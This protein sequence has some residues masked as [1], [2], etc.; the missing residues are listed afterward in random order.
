M[1]VLYDIGSV[2]TGFNRPNL[3]TGVFRVIEEVAH[4]LARQPDCD[5]QFIASHSLS[6]L[7]DYLRT[8][9]N[10]PQ[11]IPHSRLAI[12]LARGFE[13]LRRLRLDTRDNRALA[14]RLLRGVAA[15]VLRVCEPPVCR[16]PSS[17]LC[18]ADIFHSPAFTIPPEVRSTRRLRK[19]ITVYDLIPIRSPQWF[20]PRNINAMKQRLLECCRDDVWVLAISQ[21]TKDDFC[22]FTKLPPSRVFVTHLAASAHFFPVRDSEALAAARRNYGVPE[23]PFLLSVC[24]LEPRK[25]L[26]TVIKAFAELILSERIPD[27]S[28][29][30][31]GNVGWQLENMNAEFA[32]HP[33]LK[34][35]IIFTGYVPD[36]DLAAIYSAA[37]AFVYMSLYEGFGLPPLEAM[38]C[39]T[40]VIT[41]NVSSLP[42]VV[43]DAGIMVSPHDV[44]AISTAMLKLCRDSDL[45]RNLAAAGRERARQYTWD[46]CAADTLRAYREMLA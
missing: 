17:A 39:D 42:E 35:R 7:V 29:V 6:G 2:A 16:V 36:H 38:Q 41:S 40:P 14:M 46:K 26:H 11:A 33:S 21:A 12:L 4:A 43:G 27:L 23:G 19:V 18:E 45:R 15:A 13:P 5:L 3:R 9:P 10:L 44:S 20:P 22:E 28:L 37:T 31:V 25:N 24:T 8:H 1:R 32:R 34:D 30:L